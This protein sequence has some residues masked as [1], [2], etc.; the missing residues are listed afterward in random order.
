LIQAISQHKVAVDKIAANVPDFVKVIKKKVKVMKGEMM[1]QRCL[2]HTLDNAFTHNDEWREYG[3][4][5]P[6]IWNMA[7][8]KCLSLDFENG[9]AFADVLRGLAKTDEG[10][11]RCLDAGILD[12]VINKINSAKDIDPLCNL[13]ASLLSLVGTYTPYVF[14]ALRLVY[15]FLLTITNF[16]V[17]RSRAK[18]S[19]TI[20]TDYIR[21]IL[22]GIDNPNLTAKA[23]ENYCQALYAIS[24]PIINLATNETESEVRFWL[25]SMF[26]LFF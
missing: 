1:P 16:V 4:S 15:Y 11:Q 7:I 13:V 19:T 2:A 25:D 3:Y 12:L 24:H 10:K 6:S 20:S 9:P 26:R 17:C 22:D 8:D 21:I 23:A 18:L 14:A 5:K